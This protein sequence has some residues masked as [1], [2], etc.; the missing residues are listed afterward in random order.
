MANPD[1]LDNDP[2]FKDVSDEKKKIIDEKVDKYINSLTLDENVST[3]AEKIIGQNYALISIVSPNSE[4][5]HEQICLKIK[6]VFSNLE[7]ANKRAECLQKIDS[8][9]DI[10][11]VDMYSWLLIPPDKNL[12]E[13]KFVDEKLNKIIGNYRKNELQKK[14]CFNER[15]IELIN[16]INIENDE[17]KLSN[18]GASSSTDITINDDN[19]PNSCPATEP[20][21]IMDK[22]VNDDLNSKIKTKWADELDD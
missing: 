15:K 1:Y 2:L 8:T 17:K 16:N 22:M 9:F 4:Q 19:C 6:G 5:K 11:V 3:D 12:I 10:Y 20:S 13:Q 18:N 21:E 7:E 14:E